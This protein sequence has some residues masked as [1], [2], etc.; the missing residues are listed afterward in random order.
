MKDWMIVTLLV[1]LGGAI[2]GA[3]IGMVIYEKHYQEISSYDYDQVEKWSKK[4]SDVH[5]LVKEVTW[6]DNLIDKSEFQQIKRMATSHLVKKIREGETD[7][8]E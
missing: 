5:D 1:C 7:N 4:F 3:P 8:V 2:L 6:D